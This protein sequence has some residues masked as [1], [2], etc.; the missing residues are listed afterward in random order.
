VTASSILA[1]AHPKHDFAIIAHLGHKAAHLATLHQAALDPRLPPN[2]LSTLISD[3][4][5][6]GAVIPDAKQIRHEARVAT[7]DQDATLQ[8][9]YELVKAVRAAVKKAGAAKEVQRAYGIGQAVNPLLVRDVK[10]ALKL[11][12][13]RAGANPGE[14]A[15]LG[16]LKKDVEAIAAAHQAI[17]EADR[18]QDQKMARAPLGTQERNRIANR[19]LDAVARIAGAGGLEFAHDPEV[20]AMFSA[21][22]PPPKARKG[23]AKKAAPSPSV[24]G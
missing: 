4:D 22:K 16:V 12:L 18:V 9:G 19:I 2:T 3:L 21:L 11:I 7:A 14:A 24:G 17:T 6:L 13:D 5:L 20:R 10:V 8:A 1:T 23:G 15:E